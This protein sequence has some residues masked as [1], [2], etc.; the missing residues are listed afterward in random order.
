MNP[1]IL[2]KLGID[3]V[4]R[5]KLSENL[6]FPIT[7]N[8]IYELINIIDYN[9]EVTKTITSRE[10]EELLEYITSLYSRIKYTNTISDIKKTYNCTCNEEKPY[11]FCLNSANALIKCKHLNR[12]LDTLPLFNLFLVISNDYYKDNLVFSAYSLEDYKSNKYDNTLSNDEI[13]QIINSVL[14]N[15]NNYNKKQRITLL[16]IIIEFVIR[17]WSFKDKLCFAKVI[18]DKIDN[19]KSIIKTD[20]DLRLQLHNIITRCNCSI[21]ILDDW[22]SIIND[23]YK[24]EQ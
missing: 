1:D 3:H 9:T 7:H 8:Y 12:T 10:Y 19:I 21:S 16:F 18:C 20:C 11:K 15:Y 6:E 17:T 23:Y 5:L 22:L 4:S 13:G 2:A 14:P 24:I